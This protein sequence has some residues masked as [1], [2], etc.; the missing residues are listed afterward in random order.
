MKSV[1]VAESV[2]EEKPPE[3]DARTRDLLIE[4]APLMAQWAETECQPKPL[5]GMEEWANAQ[6]HRVPSCDWYHGTWQYLRLLNMVA[7]PPWYR[8][9]NKA[10]SSIL[11][12]RPNP[13]VLISGAADWG[14][15][16]ILHQ[17][18]ETAG[19]FPRITIYDICNTPLL[20][21]RWYAERHGF[22]VH[23]VRDN[24]LTTP[25]TPVDRFDLIV[26]DELLTVLKR[27][28]KPTIVTRWR[29]LLKPG[30]A[31]VTTAMIGG[32]TTREQRRDYAVRARLQLDAQHDSFR[33]FD[34]SREELVQRFD[35]FAA[36]HTRHMIAD[37]NEVRD[38]FSEFYLGFCV[39][40]ETPGECANPTNS[41]QIIA[42]VPYVTP[43]PA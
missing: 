28:D 2:L 16:A 40:T 22:E 39:P 11:R 8:F 6:G 30:G 31:V 13:H 42:S 23:C 9:Y 24:L 20:A 10:V 12:K 36:F 26:T 29:A 17:A 35:Q 25:S 27:E 19:V 15:L 34:A 21:C 1:A 37:A 5:G 14:M 41:F 32:P 33:S 3:V 7:V 4:S 38:L 43:G 18:I